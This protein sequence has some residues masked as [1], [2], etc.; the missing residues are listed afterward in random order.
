MK[1]FYIETQNLTKHNRT[2]R[3]FYLEKE[4]GDISFTKIMDP[5]TKE[6]V[7]VQELA[8]NTDPDSLLNIQTAY[9]APYKRVY[10]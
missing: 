8:G 9:I 1:T 2:F 7:S 6:N 5:A 10:L 3:F 4:S